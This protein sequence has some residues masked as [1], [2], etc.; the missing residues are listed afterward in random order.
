[1]YHLSKRGEPELCDAKYR[2]CPLG[3]EHFATKLEALQAYEKANEENLFKVQRKKKRK[4]FLQKVTV[5]TFALT[6][7]LTLASGCSSISSNSAPDTSSSPSVS[8]EA[9]SDSSKDAVLDKLSDLYDKVDSAAGKADEY[10]QEHDPGSL[11]DKAQEYLNKYS[12]SSSSETG[13]STIDKQTTL[14]SLNSLSV[15]AKGDKTGY[16]RDAFVNSSDWGKTSQSILSRD[17]TNI[18]Q[19]SKKIDS[20]SLNDPY[21]GN[22]IQ[23][24]RGNG[25]QVD[26]DH[27]VSLGDAW[28]S[29]AASNA[30]IRNSIA[31]DPANLIAVSSSAN[32][33]KGDKDAS[34][35]VPSNVS[36]QCEYVSKQVQIKVK[37]SLSVSSAEKSSIENII[38]TKCN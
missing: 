29:G 23:Y 3:G 28:E 37:Y 18:V 38:L 31:T 35:W 15:S 26:I 17:L 21:T 19:G 1:M 5:T 6:A 25:S 22:L 24:T 9:T 14:N 36:Y 30:S 13:T 2:E 16:S 12:G 4:A 20:G 33:Q 32:R 7:T 34:E 10:L 11:S 8:Q 27:I